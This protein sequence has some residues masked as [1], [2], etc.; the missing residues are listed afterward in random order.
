VPFP[1]RLQ[2]KQRFWSLLDD[3][4]GAVFTDTPGPG[5]SP[6]L[7]QNAFAEA[8]D[9][10]YNTFL[11]QQV[12]RVELVATE[13]VCP[14][15]T[16]SMTPE[17]MGISDF[18]DWDWLSERQYGSNDKFI[19]LVDADRLSQRAMTD[20]LIEVVYQNGAFKFVG[21]TTIRELQLKY[22]SSGVAPTTDA[23]V[24]Q[25]D[26]CLN[27]LANYAAGTVGGNKGYDEM[28]AKCRTFAVG[29]RFD[30][31]TI[32]GELFR[33]T[34]PLVRS[35]QN[36]PVAHKPYTTTRRL[37]AGRRGAPYVAAQQGTTGG[38]AQ[39]VPV[40]Y[41][42]AGGT[43]TGNIDGTNLTFWLPQAVITFHLYKNGVFQTLNVDY[44]ALNNQFTF[45]AG[46]APKESDI[47][48][49]E[50]WL[51]YQS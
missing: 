40:Q 45:L 51:A 9:V 17:E 18:A 24:I 15:G 31:G 34:Q 36:V 27:F 35:R 6:S 2:V 7:F 38:G 25:I 8:F 11:S 33:L 46:L 26:N 21:A 28:A 19:D 48:T 1:S 22:V 13:I 47:L 44:T 37:A 5:S 49:A 10:L 43:I 41:S 23:S 12:T 16:T 30:N 42:S 20:R 39:N 32:G 3:P 29:P 50:A 14:T 4:A